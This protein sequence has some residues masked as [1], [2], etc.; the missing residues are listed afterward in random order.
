MG[1]LKSSTEGAKA[2]MDG[3]DDPRLEPLREEARHAVGTMRKTFTARL[4]LNPDDVGTGDVRF[5][6]AALHQIGMHGWELQ[7]WTVCPESSGP[8]AY[9]VFTR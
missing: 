7:H 9:A 6:S 2:S 1:F 8:V 3:F 4:P 5:W